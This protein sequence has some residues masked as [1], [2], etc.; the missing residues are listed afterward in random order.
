MTSTRKGIVLAGGLGTR[1]HPLTTVTS[2]Q[3]L[4]VYDKPM[5]YYSLSILLL[6]GIND[7]ILISSP[8]AL[9]QFRE[10]LGDGSEWG[11]KLQYIEQA[12]PNGIAEALILSEDHIKGQPCALILGDNIFYGNGLTGF[13]READARKEGAT[14]FSYRVRDPY[15]YGIVEVDKNGKALSIEEKPQKPKSNLA[16]TGLYF[17]DENA[18]EVAKNIKPSARG[19]LEITAVNAEYLNR[20]QMFVAPLHRGFAWFDAGTIDDLMAA[21]EFVRQIEKRQGQKICCPEEICLYRNWLSDEELE[22]VLSGR[23][24]SEYNNYLRDLLA[25]RTAIE[26]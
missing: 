13:L 6:A 1:L 17:Y 2:K 16:V 5:I 24:R 10:L 18:L 8:Q 25:E 15:S 21:S 12:N 11:I 26:R 23:K 9:P 3:L 20:S 22:I 14:V 19:E 7:I 4:P